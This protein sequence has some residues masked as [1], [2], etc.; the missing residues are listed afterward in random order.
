M[1]KVRNISEIEI[2]ASREDIEKKWIYNELNK[3]RNRPN[4]D[5]FA[6]TEQVSKSI[7]HGHST[8]STVP[9]MT[10]KMPN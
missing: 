3:K 8:S 5:K 1:T 7:M 6:E 9:L 10:T 2:T 4:L